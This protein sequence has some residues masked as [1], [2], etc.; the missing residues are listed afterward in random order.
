MPNFHTL[1]FLCLCIGKVSGQGTHYI[2][3][4]CGFVL[5]FDEH[6]IRSVAVYCF[7]VMI[8]HS[9]YIITLDESST[10]SGLLCIV[11]GSISLKQLILYGTLLVNY[12]CQLAVS[13]KIHSGHPA[14]RVQLFHPL[15]HIFYIHS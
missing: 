6:Y 7:S 13:H 5:P 1:Y 10:S 4:K 8:D 9:E 15:Y 14:I 12:F 11:W 2:Y 3:Y